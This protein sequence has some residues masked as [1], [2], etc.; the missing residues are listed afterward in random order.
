M[1]KC[2][3]FIVIAACA[4]AVRPISGQS[5]SAFDFKTTP[6]LTV[7]AISD[8]ELKQLIAT[9]D[10]L[11]GPATATLP[12]DNPAEAGAVW[13]FARRLQAARLTSA[14]ESRVLAHLD[15]LSRARP[16]REAA[17]AGPRRMIKE[18]TVGKVAPPIT[19]TDLD[20]R[21]FSLADYRNKVVALIFSAE[22]CGICKAQAPYERFLLDKYGNWPFAILGVQTGSNRATAR[23]TQATDPRSSRAWWDAPQPNNPNGPIANA[24][25]VVGWPATYVIDGEGIIRFVDVRDED[26]LRAVR[27]LVEV[28]AD[29]DIAAARRK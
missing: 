9:L 7:P 22:W 29:R 16:G 13:Q 8:V 2:A 21:S 19:G 6:P 28:Q 3:C 24:W 27:Q 17:F 26:L 5:F 11:V 1:R 25:H 23:Q 4:L 12:A 10:R 15:A 14:Q 20:G 18:L